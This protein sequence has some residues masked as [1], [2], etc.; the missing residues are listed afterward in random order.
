MLIVVMMGKWSGDSACS[1]VHNVQLYSDLDTVVISGINGCCSV[2]FVTLVGVF[3]FSV[4]FSELLMTFDHL[5]F[6]VVC[7]NGRKYVCCS[8]CY[9]VTNECNETAS[10]LVVDVTVMRI[11]CLVLHVCMLRESGSVLSCV[12][13]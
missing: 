7:I 5:K 4:M 10:C 1:V 3:V 8:E 11:L 6:C 13:L 9:F 2:V 12:V